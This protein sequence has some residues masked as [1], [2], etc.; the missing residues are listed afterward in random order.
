MARGGGGVIVRCVSDIRGPLSPGMLPDQN[1]LQRR[2]VREGDIILFEDPNMKS[3]EWRARMP[4]FFFV[5]SPPWTRSLHARTPFAFEH[6]F[7]TGGSRRDRSMAL[8]R[9]H[10]CCRW[11]RVRRSVHLVF[12]FVRLLGAAQA[13]CATARRRP[14]PRNTCCSS[15]TAWRTTTCGRRETPARHASS[16]C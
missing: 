16:I 2:L 5:V 3:G 7:F 10:R 13:A 8:G 12:A 6:R 9:C 14:R 11:R 1:A 4:S 15:T